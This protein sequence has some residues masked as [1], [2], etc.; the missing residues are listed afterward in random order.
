MIRAD[1]T[2][3]V[4]ETLGSTARVVVL[5]A[6]ADLAVTAR[7]D[8]ARALESLELL[9]AT[10]CDVVLS[11][12]QSLSGLLQLARGFG[13]REGY[14]L[15]SHGALAVRLDGAM[16][17]GYELLDAVTF[18]LSAL[19]LALEDLQFPAGTLVAAEDVGTGRRINRRLGTE[20]PSGVPER[21]P[22]ARSR[23]TTTSLA[24]LHAAGIRE[25]AD[26]LAASTGLKVIP[27]GPDLCDVT[28]Q[29]ASRSAAD[30]VVHTLAAP[31]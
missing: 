21:T 11:T 8:A 6:D 12:S 4:E 9:L 13:V 16:P 14:G 5:D 26:M 27:T 28:A 22:R 7:Q 15:C 24:R 10:G 1:E 2:V 17:G 25:Y 30:D 3:P 29:E 20:L 31:R 19:K 23:G 18:D